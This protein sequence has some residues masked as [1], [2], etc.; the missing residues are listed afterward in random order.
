MS[1]WINASK[2]ERF[3]PQGE[4]AERYRADYDD[5]LHTYIYEK[6]SALTYEQLIDRLKALEERMHG[7]EIHKFSS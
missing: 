6:E 5:M 2:E 3:V 1:K 7:M 4:L